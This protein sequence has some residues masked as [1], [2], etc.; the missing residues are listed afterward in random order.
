MVLM[1][2]VTKAVICVALRMAYIGSLDTVAPSFRPA[3]PAI[4]CVAVRNMAAFQDYVLKH[5]DKYGAR[6]YNAITRE[7]LVFFSRF[8]LCM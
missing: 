3:A 2:S 5:S 4:F 6:S 7:H 1:C 8:L